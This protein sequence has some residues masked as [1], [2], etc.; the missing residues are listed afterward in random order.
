VT[1][2]GNTDPAPTS[3]FVTCTW[4]SEAQG[5]YTISGRLA[6]S[7]NAADVTEGSVTGRSCRWASLT[8]ERGPS[9]FLTWHECEPFEGNRT[10]C[11]EQEATTTSSDSG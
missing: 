7:G 11:Y 6:Q 3:V 4:D 9:L 2:G 10:F 5:A 1:I 8:V